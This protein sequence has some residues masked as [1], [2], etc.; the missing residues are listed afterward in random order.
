MVAFAS[1]QQGHQAIMTDVCA[2][3]KPAGQCIAPTAKPVDHKGQCYLI[4]PWI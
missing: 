1:E 4:Q 3:Q 2:I